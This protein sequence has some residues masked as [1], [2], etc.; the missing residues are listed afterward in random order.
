MADSSE[1]IEAKENKDN[2]DFFYKIVEKTPTLIE[3]ANDEIRN[4]KEII[5]KAVK[6]DGGALEFASKDFDANGQK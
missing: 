1:V 4:D 5:L 3:W 2:R 6:I